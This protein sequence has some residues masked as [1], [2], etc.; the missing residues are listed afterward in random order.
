VL[1]F[2]PERLSGWIYPVVMCLYGF[3]LV[4]EESLSVMDQLGA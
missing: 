2:R 3:R 1:G 4:W